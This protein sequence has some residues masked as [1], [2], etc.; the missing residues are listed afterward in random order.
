MMIK[1]KRYTLYAIRYTTAS[2][3]VFC[4]LVVHAL[5]ADATVT[6]SVDR[7]NISI[8]ES[9]TYTLTVK[10]EGLGSFSPQ[11]PTLDGFEVH[12]RHQS[13]STKIINGRVSR[14][15]AFKYIMT[16][17]KRGQLTIGSAV[18]KVSGQTYRTD[19][20]KITVGG[21]VTAPPAG[22]RV[23]GEAQNLFAQAELSTKRAYVGQQVIYT[24]RLFRSAGFWLGGA[25]Y[26]PPAIDGVVVEHLGTRNGKEYRKSFNGQVYDI[27]ELKLALIPGASGDLVI[28]P[29]TFSCR[30]RDQNSRGWLG[31]SGVKLRRIVASG[32]ELTVQNPP[33]A[34]RPRDYG[35][36][37]GQFR[38]SASLDQQRGY[39]NQPLLLRAVISGRGYLAGLN[40][41][42]AS[43][44][45]N[46]RVY[47]PKKE[48][49]QLK[50]DQGLHG[51]VIYETV[52]VPKTEGE[53]TIPPQRFS[54]FD[55]QKE[56][57]V[58]AKT[59]PF[60]ITVA[61]GEV[62]ERSGIVAKRG[63]ELLGSDIRFIK[64]AMGP[65]PAPAVVGGKT[66]ISL[67]LPPF[68]YVIL[69]YVLR[70]WRRLRFDRAYSRRSRAGKRARNCLQGLR[71]GSA[72][73]AASAAHQAVVGYVAD[74]LNL[75]RGLTSAEV[76][77]SV[78]RRQVPEKLLMELKVLL[79]DCDGL[80][81]A[82]RKVE[83]GKLVSRVEAL[84]AKFEKAKL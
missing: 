45:V 77:R 47:E 7:T 46:L 62:A 12:S 39:V 75:H 52:V 64:M 23:P 1:V 49:K 2:V 43:W 33:A 82:A 30:V 22:G 61:A 20:I 11:L 41:P 59:R 34:G 18:V 58:Q 44:P 69:L 26:D 21:A 25:N 9:F 32:L 67:M 63:I 60:L 5:A 71:D 24:V 74:R 29:V 56:K 42:T 84:I 27:W 50:G 36:A 66:L 70:H 31:R 81:F 19:P 78:Q 38:I 4:S 3:V 73:A 48:M 53:L 37:V 35:G 55:P 72:E 51:E 40:A 68:F 14:Q 80:R 65:G 15:L 76:I 79:A 28:S 16:P 6:A 13:Q 57:Y 54:F 83:T 17:K 10:G 8:G